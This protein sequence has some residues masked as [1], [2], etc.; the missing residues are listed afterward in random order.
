M[1]DKVVIITGGSS[2]IGEALAYE[3]GNKGSKVV[4]T[5]RNEERLNAV[6]QN[7][8]NQGI[9]NLCLLLDASREE[10]NKQM[11]KETVNAYGRIDVLI[12][13]AGISMR[14]CSAFVLCSSSYVS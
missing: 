1:K 12:N 3:F 11:V 4:I 9:Q 5:G 7:L 13:N 14:S 6:G 2:G 10:D 8:D